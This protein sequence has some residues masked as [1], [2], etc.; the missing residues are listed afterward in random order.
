VG[1]TLSKAKLGGEEVQLCTLQ[2]KTSSSIDLYAIKTISTDDKNAL[3]L[4]ERETQT[5]KRLNHPSIVKFIDSG[6]DASLYLVYLVLEYLEGENIKNYF[7]RGVDLKTKINLF[8]Q[9][10]DAVSYAHSKD[11]IHRDIKPENIM[12]IENDEQPL[13]KILDFGISIITTTI[14]TNTIKSYYTPLFAAPEQIK[15]KG[16]SRDSDIFSLGVTFLYLLSIDEAKY[17]FRDQCNVD[18]L[19]NSAFDSLNVI[20]TLGVSL[21]NVLKKATDEVREHR[22]KIDE[23]RKHFGT[24]KDSLSEK[25][26]VVFGLTP[27]LKE[28]ISILNSFDGQSLRIKRDVESKLKSNLGIIHIIKIKNKEEYTNRLTVQIGIDTT[29]YIYRG[30]INLDNPKEIILYDEVSF[31]NH[32]QTERLFENGLAV[33]IEPIVEIGGSSRRGDDLGDLVNQILQREQQ[34]SNEIESSKGVDATFSRWQSVIEIEKKIIEERKQSFTYTTA[35]YDNKKQL[36]I[37]TL[38]TSA[39]VS[40]I[41]KISFHNVA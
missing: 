4:L 8:L 11:V 30:F 3:K 13:A 23:I 7:D 5:L 15:L 22:P 39:S 17:N 21:V 16:V 32:Q 40:T 29:S 14:L 10:I 2:K 28:K 33:K 34:I 19:Y 27:K 1:S 6:Y 26:S 36:L 35:K 24:I 9:I 12:V 25:L 41:I 37:I 38:K 31:I 20:D 18:I